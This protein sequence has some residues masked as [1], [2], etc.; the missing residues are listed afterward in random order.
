MRHLLGELESDD[1]LNHLNCL[2]LLTTIAVTAH[3]YRYLQDHGV[4]ER[5]D[6]MIGDIETNPLGGLLLPGSHICILI[7]NTFNFIWFHHLNYC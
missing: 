5:L 4:L 2:E 6:N 3:G 7:F 1:I